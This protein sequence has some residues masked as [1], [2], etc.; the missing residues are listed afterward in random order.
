MITEEMIQ[1]INVLYHKQK[2]EGLTTEEELEQ[3]NL[4]KEYVASMRSNLRGQLNQIRVQNPDGSI[5]ELKE[6]NV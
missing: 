4:R 5:T 1:R 6:K 2:G 3:V